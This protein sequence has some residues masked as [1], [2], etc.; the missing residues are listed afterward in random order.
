MAALQGAVE[1]TAP[2]SRLHEHQSFSLDDFPVPSGREE[3]WRFTP[4]RRLR[5]LH[6]DTSAPSGKVS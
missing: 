4:L 1:S 2:V 3:E 6:S 5:R